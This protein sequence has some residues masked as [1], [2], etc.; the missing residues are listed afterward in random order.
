MDFSFLLFKHIMG[1]LDIDIPRLKVRTIFSDCKTIPDSFW[2]DLGKWRSSKLYCSY[3]L[4][5]Q[6]IDQ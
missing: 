2:V 3:I 4:E 6:K 1:I 5:R